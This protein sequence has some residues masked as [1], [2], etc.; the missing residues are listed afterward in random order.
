MHADDSLLAACDNKE[1]LEQARQHSN[2]AQIL[3]RQTKMVVYSI[4]T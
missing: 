4:V 3:K 1:E 2:K